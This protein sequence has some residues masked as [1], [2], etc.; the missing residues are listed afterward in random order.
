MRCP[1][2]DSP[3]YCRLLVKK[4]GNARDI[5]HVRSFGHPAEF[6]CPDVISWCQARQLCTESSKFARKAAARVD[7]ERSATLLTLP[8][9]ILI[10]AERSCPELQ[11]KDLYGGHCTTGYLLDVGE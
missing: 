3:I 6:S 10:G 2:D 8:R 9:S 5:F 1:D 11:G 7:T 4:P